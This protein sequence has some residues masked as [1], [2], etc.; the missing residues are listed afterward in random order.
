M[1]NETGNPSK[2][3]DCRLRNILKILKIT[4]MPEV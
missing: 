3:T 1:L 2:E 4:K